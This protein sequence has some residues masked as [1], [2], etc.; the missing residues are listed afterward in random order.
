MNIYDQ[1]DTEVGAGEE[2]TFLSIEEFDEYKAACEH[3]IQQAKD[4][5]KLAQ[6][7]EF[8][9][10]IMDAYFTVEPHRLGSLMASGKLNPKQFDDCA[11]DLRK[12]GGL[13][14][15]LQDFI[16][17]GNIASEE[18]EQLELARAEAIEAQEGGA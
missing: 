2:H 12:I 16:Q 4:A 6:Y 17:K 18:L 11:E 1:D 5:A 15:F 8:K 10:L 14:V 9:S 13:R 3:L 7:P